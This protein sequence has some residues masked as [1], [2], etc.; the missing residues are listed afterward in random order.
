MNSCKFILLAISHSRQRRSL[1]VL[2]AQVLPTGRIFL[3]SC[4]LRI[5]S[6]WNGRH[7]LLVGTNVSHRTV[8]E[9]SSCFFSLSRLVV[10]NLASIQSWC[11]VIPETTGTV[12][13]SPVHCLFSKWQQVP[14]VNAWRRI[15]YPCGSTAVFL[16]ETWPAVQS[17]DSGSVNWRRPRN[18]VWCWDAPWW[19]LNGHQT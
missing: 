18:W 13:F 17:E 15:F 3:K 16:E 8:Y 10:G 2:T 7:L 12:S 11:L 5:T 1:N 9:L 19:W 4:S 14:L 6:D